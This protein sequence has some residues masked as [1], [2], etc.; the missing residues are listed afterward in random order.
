MSI[1]RI[2]DGYAGPM[3]RRSGLALIAAPWLAIPIAL[4]SI[5]LASVA[6]VPSGGWADAA[7]RSAK[8]PNFSVHQKALIGAA[9][10]ARVPAM[11]VEDLMM[12]GPAGPE[13]ATAFM[14]D[15]NALRDESG[16]RAIALARALVGKRG[17]TSPAELGAVFER[18]SDAWSASICAPRIDRLYA[19]RAFKPALDALA[20]DIES[21]GDPTAKSFRH[22][23]LD[24]GAIFGSTPTP[25]H[26]KDS[27]DLLGDGIDGIGALDLSVPNGPYRVTLIT[28][29]M[30]VPGARV[31]DAPFGTTLMVNG[32]AIP[33]GRA[34]PSTWLTIASLQSDP[35]STTLSPAGRAVGG[36]IT[37]GATVGDGHL[38]LAFQQAETTGGLL[39]GILLE[40]DTRASQVVLFDQ[41]KM[42]A[43]PID[44]CL[45]LDKEVREILASILNSVIDTGGGVRPPPGDGGDDGGGVPVSDS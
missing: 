9:E 22:L 26:A 41:A 40:P 32:S 37:I 33:I 42:A 1:P 16:A 8:E 13:H 5:V 27:G 11:L 14:L 10:G 45:A 2:R 34:P 25:I 29:A 7:T 18:L 43:P 36:S 4:V 19:D 39:T 21:P 17:K 20:F 44:T 31:S 30:S 23:G 6:L 24:S 3:Q 12:L 35:A 38:R 28:T 15:G